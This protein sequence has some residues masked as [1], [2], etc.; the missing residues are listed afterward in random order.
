MQGPLNVKFNY[1]VVFFKKIEILNK[2]VMLLLV[3]TF[4]SRCRSIAEK[5]LCLSDAC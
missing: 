5:F 1:R 3:S 4:F 2:T